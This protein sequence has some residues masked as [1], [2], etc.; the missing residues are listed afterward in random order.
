MEHR[1]VW[2]ATAPPVAFASLDGD[3]IVDAGILGAGITG[4]TAADVLEGPALTA[5]ERITPGTDGE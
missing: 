3:I 5:L 2:E 4:I 1:S